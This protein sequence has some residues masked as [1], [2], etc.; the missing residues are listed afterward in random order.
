[1]KKEI[2][3]LD[4]KTSGFAIYNIA[5]QDFV[6]NKNG[7]VLFRNIDLAK[8][9][10]INVKHM[11]NPYNYELYIVIMGSDIQYDYFEQV[12]GM[13]QFYATCDDV[14]T[15]YFVK[16]V[17]VRNIVKVGYL[18]VN[19]GERVFDKDKGLAK[20]NLYYN[21]AIDALYKLIQTPS[22]EPNISSVGKDKYGVYATLKK[23]T[24][25][26]HIC[27]NSQIM[28][29]NQNRKVDG[30]R[31]FRFDKEMDKYTTLYVFIDIDVSEPDWFEGIDQAQQI[32]NMIAESMVEKDECLA[33]AHAITSCKFSE[34]ELWKPILLEGADKKDFVKRG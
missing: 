34:V 14:E 28:T 7:V 8:M 5:A 30:L 10:A 27:Y 20:S 26:I 17:V 25:K 12:D 32:I 1:M 19:N 2:I 11:N 15:K 13:Y 6:R 22:I 3:T 4:G 31:A 33:P 29:I 24:A 23:S 21:A 18:V 9:Y 16:P